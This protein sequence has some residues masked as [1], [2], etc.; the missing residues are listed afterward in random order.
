MDGQGCSFPAHEGLCSYTTHPLHQLHVA[1][2]CRKLQLGS[3]FWCN[4]KM[5][6]IVIV[7]ACLTSPH[8]TILEA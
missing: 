2:L 1:L 8:P 7:I 6:V 5:V 4:I 3:I